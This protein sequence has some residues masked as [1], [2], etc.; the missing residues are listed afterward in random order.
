MN[1]P[2]GPLFRPEVAAA[3]REHVHGEIVLAQ[4][5][6][7]KV[8]V[9]LLFALTAAVT[10]WLT[11]G[12]YT[13]TETARG[14]LVTSKASSK[15]LAIRPGQVTELAVREN[16]LVQP[17]QRLMAV[18]VEQA[19]D[20]GESAI[21]T[22]LDAIEAQRVLADQQIRLSG[23]KAR[24]EQARLAATLAG[25]AQQRTDLMEQVALQRDLVASV[26]QTYQQLR[27]VADKGFVSRIEAERRRQEYLTARQ[28][29]S[30]LEQQLGSIASE[31]A[32]ARAELAGL[33]AVSGT[34]VAS[35]KSSSEALV[36]QR[37]RLQG[38]RSY[39]ITAPIA[40]RVTALQ[41][42]VGRTVDGSMPL[43]VI[44]P[45]ASELRADIY[46]PTRAVGFVKPGQEVRLLYDAFP[47]QRFGSF[48]GRIAGISRV[49]IDPRE[50]DAPL[51][52]EEPV[53]RISV[54]PSEQKI[55]AYGETLPLQSGMTLTA[56]IILDRRSFLD[57]LLEPLNAVMRR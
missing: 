28:Q 6:G 27:S 35:V 57:W 48:T 41:T 46:A 21:G 34:E 47:Y 13:R 14:I 4:P 49:V 55:Q 1:A 5:L 30:R 18:R 24:S 43:M 8:L 32:R 23:L 25:F 7:T 51:K 56:N 39:V 3:R 31:E 33:A 52:I 15:I 20:A 40:G 37:A 9:L 42:A 22:S 10:A 12:Q 11:L 44:V 36:Q 50:L 38:E 17:G 19:N 16:D 54:V 26:Q 29:L 53:Y 45:E 2:P